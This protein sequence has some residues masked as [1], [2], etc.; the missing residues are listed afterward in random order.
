MRDK[1]TAYSLIYR[2]FELCSTHDKY[3]KIANF[4][5]TN[6]LSIVVIF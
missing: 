4:I 5:S 3:A 2:T 1:M 6:E